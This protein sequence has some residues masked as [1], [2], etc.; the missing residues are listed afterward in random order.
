M[1]DD[2][3]SAVPDNLS[4]IETTSHLYPLDLRPQLNFFAGGKKFVGEATDDPRVLFAHRTRLRSWLATDLHV[5]WNKKA[6]KIEEI[7]DQVTIAFSDGTTFTGDVLVGADGVSSTVRSHILPSETLQTVPQGV[8]IGQT[9]V[10]NPLLARLLKLSHSAYS[11]PGSGFRMFICLDH[12]S[13]DGQTGTYQW[14]V[15]WPDEAIAQDPTTYWT[16]T[17]SKQQMHDYALDKIQSLDLRLTELIRTSSATDMIQPP[18]QIRDLVVE[19][20]PNSRIT[21]LG[22][23]AHPMAPFRGRGGVHALLD[24]IRLADALSGSTGENV[25][26]CLKV[27]QD[28][29]LARGS[30]AVRESRSVAQSPGGVVIWGHE[31]KEVAWDDW[32][33]P[34]GWC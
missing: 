27:Y 14:F 5:H 2:V 34:L 3:V 10:T 9:T 19:A 8:V 28:E 31:V 11:V 29:M 7:D 30:Q 20:L 16:A 24:A 32:W 25:V 21:L 12:L 4:S 26:D 17:A 23:A 22:D 1:V 18:L 6:S 15:S 13:S 33:V